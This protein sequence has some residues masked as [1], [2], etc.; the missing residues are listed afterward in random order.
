M[1]PAWLAPAGQEIFSCSANVTMVRNTTAAI[2][3]TL[4]TLGKSRQKQ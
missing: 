2:L 3:A 4:C 1:P